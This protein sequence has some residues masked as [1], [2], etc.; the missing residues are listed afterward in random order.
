M[1]AFATN[2]GDR[3]SPSIRRC[4]A[5]GNSPDDAELVLDADGRA[6]TTCSRSWRTA[7]STRATNF[8]S[9]VETALDIEAAHGVATH[10]GDEVL[11]LRVPH[12]PEPGH[13]PRERR[14]QRHRRRH[15]EAMEDAAN[16]PT[17]HSVSNSLGLRR[18]GRVGPRRPVR[19]LH[20][21]HP[22]ARRRGRHE[23]LLL[24][25][26]R[27]HVPV[28]LPDRQ[29]VRR[30][31]RR[32]E[33]LVDEQHRPRGARARRGA[34]A[35]AGARP[36]SRGRPGRSAPASR[37]TAP[38][39]G[40]VSPDV[41]AIADPNTGVRF[42]LST[43][44]DGGTQSGQVGG[45]SLAAP[46]LNGLQAVD[47]E[48]RQRADLPGRDAED[49]LRRPAALPARQQRQRGQ[50]LPRHRV[51]QHGEPDQRPRRRR[52]DPRASTR[53]PAGASPTGSTSRIGIAM[54]LGATEPRPR[55][56]RSAGTSRGRA[57]RRRATRPSARSRARRRR[58]ATRS[59]PPPAA[60]PGTAS[61]SPP[62]RGAR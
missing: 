40:R 24:D 58:P 26:R 53:R 23:L 19:G 42:T 60:R 28:R 27:R 43:N 46:V 18:R 50:L 1:T 52:R 55:R 29:P 16:D 32:H 38:C 12:E 49:R 6:P 17:L 3:R 33:H 31:R 36:S 9:N 61:S 37:P 15:G 14:L 62:A 45:T 48:L 44:L 39:P 59:A 30:L 20:E 22:R 34:A 7:T 41:S 10:V 8:G 54:Q 25:R 4:I 13:R 47:A 2:T 5:T 21:Q 35:A 51:R 11:R 56:R 57:R